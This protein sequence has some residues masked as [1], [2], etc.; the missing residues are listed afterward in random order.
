MRSKIAAVAIGLGVFMIVAAGLVRFYAYPTLATV[1]ADY[2]G[3]TELEAS[4]AQVL[5][6]DSTTGP[7]P[8]VSETHDLS[9]TSR[10]IADTGADA[11]DGVVVW[12]N[13][14]TVT[15]ANGVDFQL[16]QERAAFDAVSGAA[17]DCA[18][19][20]SWVR[21][22][23]GFGEPVEEEPTE[24]A[25]QVYKFPFATEKKDYEVWDG[26]VGKAVPATFEGEEQ[27]DGL[28]VYKFVQRVDPTVVDTRTLAGE[29]FG[30]DAPT[31]D[32]DMWYSITR[33]F[34]VEPQTGSPVNRVEERTQELRYEDVTVPVFSGTVQY[35]D[36]QVA[37]LVKDT[38]SNATMLGG[39]KLLFPLLL[40]VLGLA[41]LAGG[42]VAGSKA[43]ARRHVEADERKT[44]VNA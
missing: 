18:K 36:D 41:L 10:T 16:A 27:I 9:V 13:S 25:G 37:K 21:T 14:T 33:T 34:Y 2:E 8:L 5:D 4:G 20:E 1:P 32:A 22:T 44:L 7:G 15:R 43:R 38:K 12:V 26:T 35:T 19:C 30:V 3:V 42:L 28:T 40:V 23:A 24:R 29:K 39:M 6:Y 31:V 11:P 17:V